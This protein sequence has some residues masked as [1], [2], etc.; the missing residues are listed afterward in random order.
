MH[1]MH[2]AADLD[3]NLLAVFDAVLRER[4]VTKAAQSLGLTQ[5]ATSHAVNRLRAFFDDPLFVR[6]GDSMAATKKAEA[7]RQS[8]VN[9]MAT[10]R[11]EILAAARFD[12]GTAKRVFTLCMTDMGELVF[13]PAL[14]HRMRK[15]APHCSVRTLQVSIEQIEGMLASGDADLAVGSIRSVPEGL[16]QQRLFLHSLVSIVH[17]RN[18]AVGSRLTLAQFEQMP[19]IVVS[20]TGSGTEAYDSAVEQ[21]GIR[22]NVFLTTPHFLSVPLLIERNPDLIATVP[23]ELANVFGRY[24]FLR[25]VEPPVSLPPLAL[26][27]HWHPRFHH[28]PA[29]IW[30][31]ELMKSTFE[32]YPQIVLDRAPTQDAAATR[33]PGKSRKA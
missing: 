30:L 20:L 8:V 26:N 5:S 12:P 22:R 6:S 32:N 19:Q 7:L 18:K 25:A 1:A 15:E 3:L 11:Q 29:I 33:R 13:L 2:S 10:V 23:L 28:D 9:V 21:Q 24:G 31:R 4:N 16:F 17:A 14:L 27:Q